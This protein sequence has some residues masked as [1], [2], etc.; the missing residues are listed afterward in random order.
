[1]GLSG[2]ASEGMFKGGLA[3][4]GEITTALHTTC[5]L[6]LAGMRKVLGDDISQAGSNITPERLRFDFKFDRKVE[7][8]EIKKIEEYVNSAINNGFIVNIDEMQKEKAKESGVTGAFWEKYPEIVKVYTMK[9]GEGEIYSREL[10]GGPHVERSDDYLK[11]KTFSISKQEAVSAGVRRFK[12][13]L[14]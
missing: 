3:D 2:T 13:V 7:E 14:Q 9:S 11:G 8:D 5:H 4:Q 1:M 12:G 10:C 6:M